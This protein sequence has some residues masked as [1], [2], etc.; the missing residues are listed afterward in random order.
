VNSPNK[1]GD[2]EIEFFS[3][4]KN[5]IFEC[6]V[7]WEAYPRAQLGDILKR[8]QNSGAKKIKDVKVMPK[9]N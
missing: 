8:V 7:L 9:E 4:K 1:Q 3:V 2:L 5:S 6:S